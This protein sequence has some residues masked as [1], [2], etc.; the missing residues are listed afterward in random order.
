MQAYN[1]YNDFN[2]M[3][4]M[5]YGFD[6]AQQMMSAKGAPYAQGYTCAQENDMCRVSDS[7]SQ[8]SDSNQR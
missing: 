6:V 4:I 7:T 3:K 1:T 8:N 2:L 5:P